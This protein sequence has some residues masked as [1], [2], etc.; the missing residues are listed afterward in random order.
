MQYYTIYQVTNLIN[1]NIYIGQHITD[2]PHDDYLG[3]GFAI[4]NAVRKYGKSNFKKDVL[5]IFDNFDDMNNKEK[6]LVNE[7]FILRKDVYNLCTGGTGWQTKRTVPCR[8]ANG[9]T[10]RVHKDIFDN[11]DTL[12]PL[13]KN[14]TLVADNGKWKLIDLDQYIKGYHITPSTGR[15]SIIDLETNT[16]KSI[17]QSEFDPLLHK[18]VFG[19][20]VVNGKYVTKEEYY[21]NEDLKVATSGM[22]T[23]FEIDTETWK[24]VPTEEYRNNPSKYRTAGTGFTT[25]TCK[26]T[27]NKVRFKLDEINDEI[28]DTYLFSSAGQ[29]T[30]FDKT[31]SSYKNIPKDEYHKN[32]VQY[33]TRSSGQVVVFDTTSDLKKFRFI[34]KSDFNPIIHKLAKDIK[35]DIVKDNTT[36][37]SFWGSKVRLKSKLEETFSVKLTRQWFYE[38]LNSTGDMTSPIFNCIVIFYDWKKENGLRN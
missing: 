31:T 1:N 30:V 13:L 16:T 38:F 34:P 14:K 35:I 19:G 32:K 15:I 9:K 36:I 26:I 33:L 23:A 8:D 5:F 37:F 18:S 28:R 6:E 17:R 27:G 10:R 21:N 11:D 29:V 3:S 2:D 25:G 7:E 12:T 22:V 4:L 20:I 24:H